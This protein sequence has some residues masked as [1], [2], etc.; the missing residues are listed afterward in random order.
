MFCT[1]PRM[2]DCG[3]QVLYKFLS[4]H[5]L[6]SVDDPVAVTSSSH[7]RLGLAEVFSWDM[8]PTL[9]VEVYIL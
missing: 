3:I 1:L 5:T 6:L 2:K 4:S 7:T 9:T 8:L